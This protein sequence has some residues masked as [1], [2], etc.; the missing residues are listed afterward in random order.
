M[1]KKKTNTPPSSKKTPKPPLKQSA[2]KPFRLSRPIKHSGHP[3]PSGWRLLQKTAQF[4]WLHKKILGGVLL[5]YGLLQIIMVQGILASNFSELK[6]TVD[7]SLG[8]VSTG[9]ALFSYMLSSIGQTNSAVSSVYQSFLFVLASLAFIWALR[10]LTA[11]KLLS[12]KDAYYKGMYPLVPFI[13]ILIVIG[14][15]AIPALIGAWLYGVVVVSGVAVSGIE[16]AFWLVICFT[17][18]LLSIYMICSSL[19]AAYIV[20]LP[21]MTPMKALRSARSLVL[22][23]RWS[24]ARKLIFAVLVVLIVAA[25]IMLPVILVAPLL[26]PIIFYIG[27]VIIMGFL[28]TYVYIMYR[29]LLLDE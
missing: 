27:T 5:V 21:N 4:L 1:A 15:Q 8:G 18:A 24:I 20:T 11:D 19:F 2:Y 17:F 16:Q 22:H 23:R 10:Q 9:F 28:Y 6:K 14:L 29:E 7:D 26:A 13:L 3:L 25:G 12:V